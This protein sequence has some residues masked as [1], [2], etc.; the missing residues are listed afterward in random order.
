MFKCI[1]LLFCFH[2]VINCGD[3]NSDFAE[4]CKIKNIPEGCIQYC[5]YDIHDIFK[6]SRHEAKSLAAA[7]N[8]VDECSTL[9]VVAPYIQCLQKGKD[10]RECCKSGGVDSVFSYCLDLC[11]GTRPISGIEIYRKCQLEGIKD[12][13]VKCGKNA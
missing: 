1:F 11:D 9:E 10:N 8:A 5:T 13:T 2:T 3:L 6:R 4:C 7:S 12:L